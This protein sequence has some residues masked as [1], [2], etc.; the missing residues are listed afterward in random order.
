MGKTS[1]NGLEQ[2]ESDVWHTP[3]DSEVHSLVT[4]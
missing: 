4:K 1:K 3:K 2:A